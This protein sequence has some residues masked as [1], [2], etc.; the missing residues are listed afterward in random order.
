MVEV[1]RAGDFAVTGNEDAARISMVIAAFADEARSPLGAEAMGGPYE[2][3]TAT[4]YR[5]LLPR[6]VDLLDHPESYTELWRNEDEQRRADAELMR[7]G[8][9]TIEEVPDLDLTVVQLPPDTASTG[10]HRFGGRWAATIH[11][12]AL[13]DAIDGHAVLLMK[14]TEIEL[15]YR[16]ES[17]VQ[18]QSATIR[19][20]VDLGPLADELTAKE[21]G[22]AEWEFEGVGALTPSLRPKER[23]TGLDPDEVRRRIERALRDGAA[24][25]DPYSPA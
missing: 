19:P 16:Y 9:V 17:W 22:T 5:E 20:R 10:G 7:S 6:I 1:A 13:H 4:L 24:A 23:A 21:P 18:Y 11:P 2:Q 25:F 8:R 3:T 12:M 14:G 15:L